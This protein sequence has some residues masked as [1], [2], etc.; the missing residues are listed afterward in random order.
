MMT[1]FILHSYMATV[2]LQKMQ[3]NCTKSTAI[4]NLHAGEHDI[5][6]CWFIVSHQSAEPPAVENCRCS[7]SFHIS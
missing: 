1:D 2:Q 4:Y 5:H 7:D 3:L 6:Q